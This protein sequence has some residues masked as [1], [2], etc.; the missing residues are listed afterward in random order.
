VAKNKDGFF[1]TDSSEIFHFITAVNFQKPALSS[2]ANLS[3]KLP[4]SITFTWLAVRG[5]EYDLQFAQDTSFAIQKT[6]GASTNT[7]LVSNFTPNRTYYWRV[8]AKN[9]HATGPWSNVF[10]FN[11]AWHT[12]VEPLSGTGLSVYP[13]PAHATLYVEIPASFSENT[14]SI[15]SMTG[16]L[17][18]ER[19]YAPGSLELDVRTYQPGTY[20]LVLSNAGGVYRTAVVIE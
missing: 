15:Y 7:I 11:T 14:I 9:A 10:R 18:S 4:T 17:L 1:L 8:R 20:I 19:M 13:N 5:A 3:F 2:P 16:A 6:L 12:G